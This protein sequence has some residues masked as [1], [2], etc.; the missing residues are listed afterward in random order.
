V[1]A[2]LLNKLTAGPA[3][4]PAETPRPVSPENCALWN[5]VMRALDAKPRTSK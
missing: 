5:D 3:P 2:W 4:K 1:I